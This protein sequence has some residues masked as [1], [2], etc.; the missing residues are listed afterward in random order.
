MKYDRVRRDLQ[1]PQWFGKISE[2]LVELLQVR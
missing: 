1:I 2:E